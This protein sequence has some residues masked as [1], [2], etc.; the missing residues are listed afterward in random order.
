MLNISSVLAFCKSRLKPIPASQILNMKFFYLVFINS[1][2]YCIIVIMPYMPSSYGFI[3]IAKLCGLNFVLFYALFYI[4]F[5]IHYKAF[6]YMQNLL[7]WCSVIIGI[8]A[9]FLL[10]QFNTLF[11]SVVIG[12]I[13]N[14][15]LQESLEFLQFYMDT[16]TICVLCAFLIVSLVVLRFKG[17]IIL[18]AKTAAMLFVCAVLG[19]VL[20]F[21]RHN[22]YV[23]L[24]KNEILR[25]IDVVY[26]GI[27]TQSQ[28]IAQYKELDNILSD[29]FSRISMGGGQYIT[30]N[31]KS[32]PNVVLI[33]GEST[34]RN[35][36]SLYGYPLKTTPN[37][38][39]LAESKDL[40]V[41]SDVISPHSHTDPSLAK[42]LTFSNY[43][44][45][46]TK[47]F[48]KQNIIDIMKIAG[49][50]TFW[51][52][53]QEAIS[54]YG[55]APQAIASRADEKKY[56]SIMDSYSTFNLDGQILPLLHA[57][58]AKQ[59]QSKQDN[60]FSFY[61]LHLMGTHSGYA[62]R[63]PSSF[64]A[65]S[66]QTLSKHSLDTMANGTL[67]TSKQA[68]TKST[69]INAIFYNDYIVSEIIKSFKDDEAII[70]YFSDHG[71]EVY[72]FRDFAGHSESMVSRYMLEIPFMIYITPKL[73]QT[74]PKLLQQI[75]TAQNL[76]FMNDDFIHSFLDILGINTLDS[77]KE[78]SI[79]SKEF[80][81]KRARLI[82]GYDYDRELHQESLFEAPDKIWLHR[83]DE[84]KK[85][86]DFKDKFANVEIDVHFLNDGK[87]EG[88]FDVGHDG[89]Q[90]SI[91]LR[92]EDMLKIITARDMQN[93][94]L[95]DF[96]GGG[97]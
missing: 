78:R 26:N 12:V 34:Q 31:A 13:L 73:R 92:L 87:G 19:L 70:F 51:I 80:N 82:G 28:M 16:K 55:N 20:Y 56:T 50:K 36:M 72:D 29:T 49:Y 44:N 32:I 14:T 83:C 67:L 5:R 62:N 81:A 47:W 6:I 4:L 39:T 66:P 23:L 60:N 11:S 59:S 45:T 43:E 68:K 42:A 41:F 54:I 18:G 15:N 35:Y 57:L 65:F 52:S 1:I 8:V 69:Y 2:F 22:I 84:P 48:Y 96:N 33:I 76:P 30:T 25:T 94:H 75:K 37:L 95:Q 17:A 10:L 64:S 97:Q 71:D 46:Q 27:I 88:R 90:K 53:N 9:I 38:D 21:W 77:D 61:V 24:P 85:F 58:K 93:L 3:S 63:Y 91:G 74:Q 7:V 79:F 86:K 89:A 40:F